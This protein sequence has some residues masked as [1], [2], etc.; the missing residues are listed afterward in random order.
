MKI[1][2]VGSRGFNNYTSFKQVVSGFIQDGDSIVSGGA[3]KGADSMAELYAKEE[4]IEIKIFKADWDK[5]HEG[6]G[7]IRNGYIV[8]ESDF[9]IAFWDGTSRGTKDTITK[10]KNLNKQCIII[11]VKGIVNEDK[12]NHRIKRENHILTGL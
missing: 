7:M 2:I 10:C 3:P 5:Y 8:D 12:N 4:Y 6:A 1:G 11:D 9:V